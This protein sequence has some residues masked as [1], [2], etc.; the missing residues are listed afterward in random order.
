MK[1]NILNKKIYLWRFK[2]EEQLYDLINESKIFWYQQKAKLINA[3]PWLHP[4]QV[5]ELKDTLININ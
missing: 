3:I 4:Q 2:N 1:I 5:K